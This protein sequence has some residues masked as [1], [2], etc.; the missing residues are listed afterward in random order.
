[1]EKKTEER[2]A[3]KYSWI[4]RK[5]SCS[6]T[7]NFSGTEVSSLFRRVYS[8]AVNKREAADGPTSFHRCKYKGRK[9]LPFFALS[10]SLVKGRKLRGGLNGIARID[11]DF[12]VGIAVIFGTKSGV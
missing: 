8:A 9:F 5:Q 4:F 1:M 2:R 10:L 12:A 3:F 7:A 6:V 11:R